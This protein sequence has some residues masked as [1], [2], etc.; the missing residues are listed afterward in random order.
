MY[1]SQYIQ[2]LQY[3]PRPSDHLAR[4]L[5]H[6]NSSTDQGD[7]PNMKHRETRF[8]VSM[9]ANGPGVSSGRRLAVAK[10]GL[11]FKFSG[12]S[13]E[14]LPPL[15]SPATQV[16]GDL[17]PVLDSSTTMPADSTQLPSDSTTVPGGS[18]PMARTFIPLSIN[19]TVNRDRAD[20]KQNPSVKGR[21]PISRKERRRGE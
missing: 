1:A 18:T 11:R 6:T 8:S 14:E 12:S 15:P 4:N 3:T 16:L 13:S 17:T 21:H 2:I 7:P 10:L 9:P 19:H 5:F 20:E